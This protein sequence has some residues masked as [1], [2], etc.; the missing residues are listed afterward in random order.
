MVLK[1]SRLTY[2]STITKR[3]TDS[4]HDATEDSNHQNWKLSVRISGFGRFGKFGR[5]RILISVRIFIRRPNAK[6]R[7][8]SSQFWWFQCSIFS[9]LWFALRF[10]FVEQSVSRNNLKTIIQMIFLNFQQADRIWP[11]LG[12]SQSRIDDP[13]SRNWSVKFV[14]NN[15]QIAVWY[16]FSKALHPDRPAG[17][18][19]L[20]I[21]KS[22]GIGRTL[23]L[24]AQSDRMR[25]CRWQTY[26]S[27]GMS[28][29]RVQSCIDP[30][31]PKTTV[32]QR[33]YLLIKM[34]CILR[35]NIRSDSVEIR[36]DI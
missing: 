24:R 16:R 1:A 4:S 27:T 23:L 3:S 8:T 34:L 6:I 26:R 30:N 29:V 20:L 15:I 12:H 17:C 22:S 36:S 2:S 19:I 13:K 31:N 9:R 14:I 28:T 35:E 5:D 10:V 7:S 25:F 21:K 11:N 18:W 32:L 33:E